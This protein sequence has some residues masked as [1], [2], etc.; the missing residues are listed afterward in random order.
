MVDG[1]AGEIPVE[2]IRIDHHPE[3]ARPAGRLLTEAERD[4]PAWRHHLAESV[5]GPA[6]IV[7][8]VGTP[9]P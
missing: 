3:A 8:R 1:G 4:L 7:V 2:G 6:P 9:S 5:D